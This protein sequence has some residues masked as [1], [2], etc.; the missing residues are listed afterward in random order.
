MWIQGGLTWNILVMAAFLTI[1]QCRE[2]PVIIAN[3]GVS[4][5]TERGNKVSKNITKSLK[6]FTGCRIWGSISDLLL[7]V[8]TVLSICGYGA[9][10]SAMS[11]RA[12][13]LYLT[14]DEKE[15]LWILFGIFH[16]LFRWV[17]PT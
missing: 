17:F 4:K 10:L 3:A 15:Y 12:D 13:T 1:P 7:C 9:I 2:E 5:N 16:A 11:R 14:S 8:G 6:T